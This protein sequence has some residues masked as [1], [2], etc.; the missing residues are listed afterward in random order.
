M[1]KGI[2]PPDLTSD[3]G[4]VRA[5]VGDITWTDFDPPQLGFGDYRYFSDAEI[6]AFLAVSGSLEGAIALAYNSLATSAAMEARSIK[7]FDLQVSTEK[8]AT[9]LRLLSAQWSGKA[10]ALSAD[11]FEVFDIV[12]ECSCVP[13]L[14]PTPVCRRGC[15]GSQ[16]F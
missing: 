3:L 8:R 16:L 11:I 13:E 1:N 2:A 12:S 5:I 10:D 15:R 14:A 7:D 9:E 4:R 6:E